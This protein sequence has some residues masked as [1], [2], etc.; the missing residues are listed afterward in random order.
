M[1]ISVIVAIYNVEKYLD[2]CIQS[3]INQD[4]ADVEFLLVDDGS[5]DRSTEICD[6]WMS[7][8]SRI[9]VI[10]KPNGGLSDARN[11]GLHTAIG[12]YIMFLD[13]DDLLDRNTLN[14]LYS[15]AKETDS[16]FIQY[17]YRE[18]TIPDLSAL[19][20]F[21]GKYEVV[22]DRHEM[23]LRLY[24]LGGSA[25]S[26]CTKLLKRNL[27]DRLSYQKGK[28]HEDEFFTTEL[29]ST[30]KTITYITSFTPYQY[31]IRK[32][33]IITSGLKPQRVYDLSEM[34]K[35]RLKVLTAFGF[36]DL[37][38]LF[39][40][41]YFSNLYFQYLSCR[42][43]YRKEC[44]DFIQDQIVKLSKFPIPELGLELKLVK[45]MPKLSLPCF[46]FIRKIKNKS[47][48]RN[49]GR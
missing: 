45:W 5:I 15:V 12:E 37:S 38:S 17:G 26:G 21:D 13:G 31:I 35:I 7:R 11:A 16:D 4:F 9:K 22:S 20:N 24:N 29:L 42:R 27:F 39:R 2:S 3:L 32:G 40:A 47:G 36:D 30:A 28:L 44:T 33:S 6:D 48:I 23:F 10:H 46:Y 49:N 18:T 1:L 14:I 25:A 41:R 19:A 34:Y 43:E 8:D